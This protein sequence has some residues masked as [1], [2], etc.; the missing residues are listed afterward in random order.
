MKKYAV[1]VAGGSGSRMNS[2]VPKQ[3]LLLKNKP[4]LY[5]TIATFLQSYED[6][7]IILVLPE[8]HVATGQE[9][10][11]AWFDYKRIRITVG[12]RTRFHSVQ[13]GLQLVEEE[14]MVIVH[15]AVRCLLSTSLIHRCYEAALQSGAAIPVIDCKDSVRFV[16][17]HG[18]EALERRHVK[19]VQTPQVFL[20]TILLP[21]YNID[22][23]DKFTDEASVVE[24]FG[25]KVQ[26]V[27]GE[28]NNI[29]ITLLP[30]IIYAEQILENRS[31]PDEQA[32]E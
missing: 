16:S 1:I 15:D 2:T 17:A 29:K 26:L 3:F 28:E 14:S 18:N 13:N 4:V 32:A 30:D 24:A 20:S 12:G 31:I 25:M 27:E 11:D 7:N 19:L 21:A 9:I 10:I 8:E 22:Y 6:L 23:K 5:Y